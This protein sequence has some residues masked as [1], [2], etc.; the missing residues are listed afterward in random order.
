VTQLARQGIAT[1]DL[2]RVGDRPVA[3]LIRLE[4]RGLAIPWK[5]AFDEEFALFS[6][7]KQLMCDDT[8]RWLLDP[9]VSRVDPVCDEGNPLIAGLWSETELYGTLLL[10]TRRWGLGARLRAGLANARQAGRKQA[11]A[12]LRGSRRPVKKARKR[13]K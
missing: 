6:P 3:A 10:S 9:A 5:I 1:I 2:M 4:Q 8:R 7:G 11:K 12:L 13:R